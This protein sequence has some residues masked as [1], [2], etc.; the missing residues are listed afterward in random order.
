LEFLHSIFV[1]CL[2]ALWLSTILHIDVLLDTS[3]ASGIGIDGMQ[4]WLWIAELVVEGAGYG[5]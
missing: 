5:V 4:A 2:L 3:R 1:E